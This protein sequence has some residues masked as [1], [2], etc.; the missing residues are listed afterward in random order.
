MYSVVLIMM[1]LG[2]YFS[3][4]QTVQFSQY[5]FSPL[6]VNPAM[7]GT[8]RHLF[9]GVTHRSQWRNLERP[10]NASMA[11]LVLPLVSHG[12]RPRHIGG[13]GLAVNNE[14]AGVGHTYRALGVQVAAAYNLAF[15]RK[16]V[17]RLSLGLQGGYHQRR[18]TAGSLQWG[19]QFDP[20]IGFNPD[21]TPSLGTLRD[22]LGFPSFSTGAVYFFNPQ[23]KFL[24]HRFSAFTGL[25]VANLNRPTNSFF[26]EAPSQEP[27]ILRWHTGW[28]VPLT[29]STRLLPHVL[30]VY[31]TDQQYHINLGAYLHYTV[32]SLPQKNAADVQILTG[33]WYRWND[34]WIVTGGVSYREY[35]LGVSYD[36]NTRPIAAQAL[37]GGA[38][39]ISFAYRGIGKR[40]AFKKYST[41]MI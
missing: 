22:K 2:G 27:M 3:Q 37:T 41:P 29:T 28:E 40:S 34:A 23:R 11:S 30:T 4:A 36:F 39:E 24:L 38:F 33:A 35:L 5:Y 10:Y 14:T 13:I 8:Q 26:S 16:Q 6:T 15:D 20:E 21:I 18:L 9:A 25:A 17:H 7:T 32:A 1:L 31:S 19:S 12:R